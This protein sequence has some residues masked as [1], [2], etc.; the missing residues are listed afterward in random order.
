MLVCL[1]SAEGEVASW[2][3]LNDINAMP[4]SSRLLITIKMTL[5]L[6]TKAFDTKNTACLISISKAEDKN[7]LIIISLSGASVVPVGVHYLSRASLLA[8]NH[9]GIN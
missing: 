8:F 2:S 7:E 1:P 6:F 4:F 3:C 5:A 9:A